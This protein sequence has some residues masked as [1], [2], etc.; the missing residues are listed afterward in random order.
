MMMTGRSGTKLFR[1]I[2]KAGA[3]SRYW[4]VPVRE[5]MISAR[6]DFNIYFLD[7]EMGKRVRYGYSK[8]YQ[9][10]QKQALHKG[11]FLFFVTGYREYMEGGV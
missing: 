1:L 10:E 3:R 8:A 11:A 4:A 7:I 5:E 2:Q 9:G 6:E